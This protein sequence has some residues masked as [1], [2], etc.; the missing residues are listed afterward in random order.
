MR[1][2]KINYLIVGV[3]VAAAVVSAGIAVTY[4]RLTGQSSIYEQT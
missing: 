2:S 1:S 3:F 4:L